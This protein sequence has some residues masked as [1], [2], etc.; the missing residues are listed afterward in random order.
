VIRKKEE[1]TEEIHFGDFLF[2]RKGFE[3]LI[4][5]RKQE[6]NCDKGNCSN[7]QVDIEAAPLAH[8][9]RDLGF[10]WG[11]GAHHQRQET[12]S[13][14][15]PPA[16]GPA[17]EA[18]AFTHPTVAKNMGRCRNGTIYAI[19]VSAPAKIPFHQSLNRRAMDSIQRLQSQQ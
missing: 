7:G 5:D 3:R 19:T 15:A 6:G 9:L 1:G 17:T 8:H 13:V 10:L 14:N 18:T 12:C 4:G 16:R 2:E 11:K